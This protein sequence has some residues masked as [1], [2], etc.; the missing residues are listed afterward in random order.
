MD[1]N[2]IEQGWVCMKSVVLAHFC[3][4]LK[5]FN[6][7]SIGTHF[8]IFLK[9]RTL[10]LSCNFSWRNVAVYENKSKNNTVQVTITYLIIWTKQIER[11][12]HLHHVTT[13]I[14]LTLFLHS[15]LSSI[16]LILQTT[17]NI[18]IELMKVLAGRPTLVQPSKRVQRR[19]SFMNSSYLLQQYLAYLLCLTWIAF[20]MGG[21]WLYSCHFVGC[22]FQDL[23]KTACC[24]FVSFPSR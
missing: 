24:I 16:G 14:F 9:I 12:H 22:Y 5:T 2:H 4:S 17:P 20:E 15:S 6:S 23:S 1:S 10:S 11:I 18:R 21:N 8:I 7:K 3:V 19:M 13:Q